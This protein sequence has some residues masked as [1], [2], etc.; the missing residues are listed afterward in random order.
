MAA[1]DPRAQR[2]E[3]TARVLVVEDDAALSD[4]FA[5]ILADR[6]HEVSIASDVASA[7][8]QLERA[9]VDV[10]V[11]DLRLP[12]A[13]GLE[14]LAWVQ[15][16][17]LSARV[18]VASAFATAELATHARRLGAHGVLSKPIEPHALIDA[19]EAA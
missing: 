18:I 7:I 4:L 11:T 17:G 3:G 19:V 13:S 15:R 14:L 10:V 8:D 6:G 5:Q 1:V 9:A 2:D 16:R 12:G